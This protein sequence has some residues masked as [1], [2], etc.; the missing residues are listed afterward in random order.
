MKTLKLKIKSMNAPILMHD[1]KAANPMNEY[2]KAMKELTSKR[3]KTDENYADIARIEWEAGLYLHDGV[4][5]LPARCLEKTFLLGARKSKL[6]KQYE[7]GV[8]LES[9]WHPLAYAGTKIVADK[10]KA[11]PNPS[12]D[13]FFIEHSD[14]Q[15]VRVG[16]NQ[17]PRCRPIF[18]DWSLECTLLFDPSII[19]QADLLRACQD[20]GRLVGLLEQRPR[21]GRFTVEVV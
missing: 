1:N 13:K 7:S 10:T 3:G 14:V 21:L 5:S 4:V 15:M 8:F 2:A 6:G 18:H 19:Q 9:D 11:L 17:V 20:A 16:T 12:L